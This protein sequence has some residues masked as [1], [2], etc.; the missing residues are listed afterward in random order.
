MSQTHYPFTN[1]SFR[2]HEV[3]IYALGAV[4]VL[5]ATT[6]GWVLWEPTVALPP[7]MAM[8]MAGGSLVFFLVW[9]FLLSTF[10]AKKTADRIYQLERMERIFMNLLQD[11]DNTKEITQEQKRVL[12]EGY[13]GDMRGIDWTVAAKHLGHVHFTPGGAMSSILETLDRETTAQVLKKIEENGGILPYQQVS[14][15]NE[16]SM[17]YSKIKMA[18]LP[19]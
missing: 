4:L 3:A 16:L 12:F 1:T 18:I 11:I 19:T 10:D 5:I 14:Q 6:I 17:D 8:T 7:H 9:I 2:A 13:I 15:L